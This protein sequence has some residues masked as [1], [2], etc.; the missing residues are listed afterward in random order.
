MLQSSNK[1][2]LY[3]LVTFDRVS[4]TAGA[5]KSITFRLTLEMMRNINEDGQPVLETGMYRVTV[6]GCSPNARGIALGAP[7]PVSADFMVGE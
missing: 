1:V 4:L 6:G 7:A 2:P 3:K 5:S